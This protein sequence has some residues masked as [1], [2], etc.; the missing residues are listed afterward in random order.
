[1]LG[2]EL[3]TSWYQFSPI[4]ILGPFFIYF[5]FFK[6]TA[7]ILQQISVKNTHPVSGAVIR[8]HNLQNTSLLPLPLDQASRQG[9]GS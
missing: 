8:T 2:F 5:Q 3:T 4:A 6:Q 7:Q 1:M 9:I